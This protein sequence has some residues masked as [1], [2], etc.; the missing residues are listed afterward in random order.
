[1][2]RLTKTDKER[3]ALI[4]LCTSILC[5]TIWQMLIAPGQIILGTKERDLHVVQEAMRTEN[6]KVALAGK[7]QEE[8]GLIAKQVRKHE[9]LMAN[10]D[11]YRWVMKTVLDTPGSR[12]IEITAFEPPLI[13][14]LS[15]YPRVPFGTATFALTGKGYYHDFGTFLAA[16]EKAY[17]HMRV[18]RLDL[19]PQQ[20]IQAGSEEEE[21]LAFRLEFTCLLRTNSL[22]ADLSRP[23]QIS[24]AKP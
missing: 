11:P 1:M 16:F 12:R 10:G 18:K 22:A 4:V 8:L 14:D 20:S 15:I 21:K 24:S 19:Q 2:N 3:L 5:L 7:L 6:D 9:A 13:G 17:P 23:D